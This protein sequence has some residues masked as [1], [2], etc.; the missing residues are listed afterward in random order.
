M[1][2]KEAWELG[3]QM[4]DWGRDAAMM[5]ALHLYP[6]KFTPTEIR[7]IVGQVL[8]HVPNHI[9]AAAAIADQPVTDVWGTLARKRKERKAKQQKSPRSSSRHRN[10]TA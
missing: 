5:L 3:F 1:G 9:V 6:E 10:A 2:E 7:D 4:G 8:V